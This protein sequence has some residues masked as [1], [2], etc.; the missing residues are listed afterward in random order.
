MLVKCQELFTA[1]ASRGGDVRGKLGVKDRL[2]LP[3]NNG[4]KFS[5]FKRLVQIFTP[6][7]FFIF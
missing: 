6:E 5:N 3:N 7:F 4:D 2:T 1:K